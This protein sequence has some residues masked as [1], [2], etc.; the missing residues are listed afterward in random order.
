MK[1]QANHDLSRK[2]LV[3]LYR[4]RADFNK[5]RRPAIYPHEVNMEGDPRFP[6]T[7]QGLFERIELGFSRRISSLNSAH[8]EIEASLLHAQALW[9]DELAA[10]AKGLDF[11]KD[12]YEEY[13][14]L[15]LLCS[16][17]SE[18]DDEQFDHMAD[19]DMRRNAFKNRLDI[20]DPF[21]D[22]LERAIKE[23]E[24]ILKSKLK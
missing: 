5:F 9:G 12:E 14:R 23:F 10:A 22:D 2:M 16:D 21:G 19:L 18:P 20:S 13:V 6:P 24:R 4:F 17:P 8:A 15:R 11:L 3:E 1:G 7:E